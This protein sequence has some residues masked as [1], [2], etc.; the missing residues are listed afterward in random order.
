MSFRDLEVFEA[1]RRDDLA[2]IL[3]CRPEKPLAGLLPE[4]AHPMLLND[5]S[6][7]MVS[8]FFGA[9]KCFKYFLPRISIDYKDACVLHLFLRD[10]AYILPLLVEIFRYLITLIMVLK[11]QNSSMM[12]TILHCT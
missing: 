4:D 6:P 5:P 1:I 8:A 10:T 11:Q 12:M 2:Y 3:A 9:T 7:L